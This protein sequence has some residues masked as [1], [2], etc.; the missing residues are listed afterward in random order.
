MNLSIRN[1][2][3]TFTLLTRISKDPGDDKT[4]VKDTFNL[5]AVFQVKNQQYIPIILATI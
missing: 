5:L 4:E 2:F 3:C 1:H